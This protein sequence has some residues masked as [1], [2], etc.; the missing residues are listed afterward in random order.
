M[1]F[2]YYYIF[3]YMHGLGLFGCA[4]FERYIRPGTKHEDP[5]SQLNAGNDQ[6]TVLKTV[7]RYH[8]TIPS[9]YIFLAKNM[10]HFFDATKNHF[11]KIVDEYWIL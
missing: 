6:E 4:G 2:A 1:H 10:W 8:R 3:V 5:R 11:N 7:Q 9:S